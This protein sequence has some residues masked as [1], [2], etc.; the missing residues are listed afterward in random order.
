MGE[1]VMA[2]GDRLR[3]D[4]GARFEEAVSLATELLELEFS[5]HAIEFELCRYHGWGKAAA[6]RIVRTAAARDAW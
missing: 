1:E 5:Q 6:T 2:I 3:V 4:S